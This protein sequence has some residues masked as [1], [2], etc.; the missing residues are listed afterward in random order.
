MK[1]WLNRQVGIRRALLLSFGVVLTCV[2][3][4]INFAYAQN[5]V[6]LQV[7]AFDQ[8]LQ[9]YKNAEVAF[10]NLPWFSTNAKGT[11]IV[12]LEKSEMP[13]RNVRFRDPKIEAASWN[14][15]KG[16]IEIIVRP[17]NYTLMKFVAKF[18]DGTVL[19]NTPVTFNGA[20]TLKTT[21]DRDGKFDLPISFN[22]RITSATQFSI[23]NLV[24]T[25]INL[26]ANEGTLTVDRPRKRDVPEVAQQQKQPQ[27]QPTRRQEQVTPSFDITDLDTVTTLTG[28]YAMFRNVSIVSLSPTVRQKVDARFKEL[29]AGKSTT[30]AATRPDPIHGISEISRVPADIRILLSK[31]TTEKETFTP[32]RVEVSKKIAAIS[33][34]LQKGVTLTS[35]ERAALQ[36]DLDQLEKVV[37]ENESQLDRNAEGY[38]EIIAFLREKY[39]GA[40]PSQTKTAAQRRL[41]EDANAFRN[42]LFAIGAIVIL[43]ALVIILL[44]YFITKV[45]RQASAL[46]RAHEEVERINENL[47]GTVK[48]RTRRFQDANKELDTF[49]RRASHDLRSPVRTLIGLCERPEKI[50]QDELVNKVQKATTNMDRVLTK[51]MDISEIGVESKIIKNTQVCTL[52]NSARNKQQKT[53]GTSA[54]NVEVECGPDL[55][56]PTSPAL[57]EIIVANLVENAVHFSSLKN[58]EEARVHVSAEVKSEDL[59]ITV[60]D[61]GVGISESVKTQLFKMFFTG[62]ES[63][64]GNGLGLYAVQKCVEA[65]YGKV[66]VESEEGKF[67]RVIVSIPPSLRGDPDRMNAMALK[68]T[69]V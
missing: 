26:S 24:V 46:Q 37:N 4:S 38:R 19:A 7:K 57:L 68:S 34:K 49:L 31:A 47:D 50:S 40:S 11:A 67:T 52:I 28:F 35:A 25:A 14:L 20:T 12:E 53:N 64:K 36:R 41:D 6:S 61:N 27:Q 51:L 62:H 13:I 18:A 21:T 56:F 69:V 23:D 8:R 10:N 2:I 5:K 42:Q 30:T 60:Y 3:T 15:S 16:T 22:E 17:R 29:A 39:Y 45:R 33:S 48:R 32:A 65:L 54:V 44:V 63:S 58:K 55:M 43:S 1:N 9:P 59:V 66:R